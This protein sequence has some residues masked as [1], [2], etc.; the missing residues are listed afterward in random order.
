[1]E[2][3]GVGLTCTQGIAALGEGLNRV[4]EVRFDLNHGRDRVSNESWGRGGFHLQH[5]VA[6]G[7]DYNRVLGRVFTF[8]LNDGSDRVR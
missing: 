1:M 7:E 2:Y 5:R 8:H 3:I 6:L 4:S